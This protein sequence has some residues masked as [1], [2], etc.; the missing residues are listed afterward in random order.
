MSQYSY[1]IMGLSKNVTLDELKDRYKYLAKKHHSDKGGSS[2]F[3]KQ[4]LSAYKDISK[5]LSNNK[6]EINASNYHAFKEYSQNDI[7]KTNSSINQDIITNGKLDTNKFN[8]YFKIPY[9]SRVDKK[10]HE[11]LSEREAI[12]SELDDYKPLVS[13]DEFDNDTFQKLYEYYNKKTNKGELKQFSELDMGIN[14]F[15]NYYTYIKD[16]NL[17]PSNSELFK[18]NS[19]NFGSTSFADNPKSLDQN[20]FEKIKDIHRPNINL[21]EEDRIRIK[22]D[23][24]QRLE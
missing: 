5:T 4:I 3:F 24:A 10:P 20:V 2:E 16:S 14:S 1:E 22:Q 8:K 21:T 15:S 7:D 6:Q 17:N 11:L 12:D 23:L 9:D 19:S 18:N 13:K